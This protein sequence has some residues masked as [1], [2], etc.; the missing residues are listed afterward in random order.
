MVTRG[1]ALDALDAGR[2]VLERGCLSGVRRTEVIF[3]AVPDLAKHWKDLDKVRSH[4]PSSDNT[5]LSVR[6]QQANASR[7]CRYNNPNYNNLE[8]RRR[9]GVSNNRVSRLDRVQLQAQDNT[10]YLEMLETIHQQSY[11]M[12]HKQN[13]SQT[14]LEAL[15]SR[16]R[17]LQASLGE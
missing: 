2:L 15:I 4:R 12:A 6:R 7:C 14:K 10:C 13:T 3:E 17:T 5:Q 1:K 9:P 16:R 8:L 11:S